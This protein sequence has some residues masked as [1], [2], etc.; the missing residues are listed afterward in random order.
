MRKVEA[1]LTGGFGNQCFIYAAGRAASLRAGCSLVLFDSYAKNDFRQFALGDF[2]C[3]YTRKSCNGKIVRKLDAILRNRRIAKFNKQGG[4]NLGN[5]WFDLVGRCPEL[6]KEWPG[7][8]YLD[9]Y[10]QSENLFKQC[11]S[12]I[13]ADFELKDKGWVALDPM[14]ERIKNT[15]NATFCH[16]RSYKDAEPDGS[17]AMPVSF[18]KNAARELR[19]RIRGGTVFLFSDDLEWSMNRLGNSFA[20]N[21]FE[22]VP[23]HD[24]WSLLPKDKYTSEFLRDFTLMRLCKHAIIPNSTFSWWAAWLLEH[25]SFSNGGTPIVIRPAVGAMKNRQ[26]G[27]GYWPERWIAVDPL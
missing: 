3:Q 10:F 25:K 26:E 24:D 4:D 23:V 18:F 12:Q 16:V 1:R 21:G 2:H 13:A 6:P 15:T 27:R 9:G 19:R 14:A 17:M 7:T 8:L 11:E 22:L 5:Y 20:E